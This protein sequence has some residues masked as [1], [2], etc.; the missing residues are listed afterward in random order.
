MCSWLSFAAAAGAI[1]DG[2]GVGCAGRWRDMPVMWAGSAP[3]GTYAASS[4][5]GAAGAG[6][7][8]WRGRQT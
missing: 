1:S 7:G 2:I 4:A 5:A 8:A 6:A 3:S